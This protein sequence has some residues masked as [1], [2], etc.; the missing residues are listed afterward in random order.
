[1]IN[2]DKLFSSKLTKDQIVTYLVCV[3]DNLAELEESSV[4]FEHTILNKKHIFLDHFSN[5]LVFMPVPMKDN[6]FEKVSMSEFFR[7]LLASVSYDEQD[8]LRFFIRLHNYLAGNTN[9]QLSEFKGKLN[10]FSVAD[11]EMN[12]NFYS[13]GKAENS[14]EQDVLTSESS[15]TKANKK[16]C[17]KLEIEEEVQYKRITRVGFGEED[18]LVEGGASVNGVSITFGDKHAGGQED[19]NEGTSVLGAYG[20]EEEEGT[21]ALGVANAFLPKPFLV[22][23]ATREK[24]VVTKETFTIGRDPN[25]ADYASKNKGVGRIHAAVETVDGEYF[26]IDKQSRNGSFLN[27]VKLVPNEKT[28]IKHDDCIRLGNQEFAFKLF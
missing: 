20:E 5:R 26:L 15:S 13:P 11:R 8:D 25:Q 4:D 6:V 28:K 18:S 17:Q 9:L 14:V 7:D 24:I 21:T 16:Q 27:G 10:E 22:E 2:L 3:V 19:E 1:M 23:V 12:A